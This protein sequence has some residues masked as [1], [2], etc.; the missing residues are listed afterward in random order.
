MWWQS[1]SAICRRRRV[2]RQPWSS[3]GR[4]WTRS[5]SRR[6]TRTAIPKGRRSSTT[7]HFRARRHCALPVRSLS[8]SAARSGQ[9]TTDELNDRTGKAQCLLA[10][11]WA[12]VLERR[13]FGMAVRVARRDVERVQHL[14]LLDQGW[15]DTRGGREIAE[16]LCHDVAPGL[17]TEVEVESLHTLLSGLVRRETGPFVTP[18]AARV[19]RLLDVALGLSE[20][21][22]GL[23]RHTARLSYSGG[24]HRREIQRERPPAPVKNAPTSSRRASTSD[25]PIWISGWRNSGTN[26][27]RLSKAGLDVSWVP[28]PR[29]KNRKPRGRLD[30][31]SAASLAKSCDGRS[32]S[33][34]APWWVG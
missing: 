18:G 4:C 19:R 11:K 33:R 7:A 22:G 5:T 20:P 30:S 2:S 27:K 15:Q 26:K 16:Q 23:S 10:L 13:P 3:R 24:A 1:C 29:V 21:V 32:T 25:S 8:S 31:Q 12:V 14:P 6:A 17:L 34:S 28:R 9:T